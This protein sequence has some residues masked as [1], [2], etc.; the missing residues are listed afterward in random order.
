MLYG[1]PT[2]ARCCYWLYIDTW[3][4]IMVL[5]E[6]SS[7]N[8]LAC[9][10]AVKNIKVRVTRSPCRYPSLSLSIQ[11]LERY[12]VLTW[13]PDSAEHTCKHPAKILATIYVKEVDLYS[14]FIVAPHTQ[15]A[16]VGLRTTQFNLQIT[17]Y[18]P[19]PH[20]R[21]PDGASPDW[22]CGRLIAAYYSFIYPERKKG[23]VGLVGW[24]TADG[25]PT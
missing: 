24:P 21:L 2:V 1:T 23:L 4:T 13:F 8:R 6:T 17:Q 19:L 9:S 20:K 11:R 7:P 3:Q 5:S 22:G 14:A 15:G 25:L 16:Q 10:W 12:L 18:L